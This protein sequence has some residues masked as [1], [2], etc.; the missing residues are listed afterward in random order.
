M[1]ACC[2]PKFLDSFICLTFQLQQ[3]NASDEQEQLQQ[4]QAENETLRRN[5]SELEESLQNTQYLVSVSSSC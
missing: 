3:N 5:V 2:N 1:I 4:L